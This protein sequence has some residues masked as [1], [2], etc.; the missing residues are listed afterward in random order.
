MHRAGKAATPESPALL[1]VMLVFQQ[2]PG[3]RGYVEFDAGPGASVRGRIWRSPRNPY[4]TV[5]ERMNPLTE[6]L[7]R[8]L[9]NAGILYIRI[10]LVKP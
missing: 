1:F 5:L 4:T 8:R 9:L 2:P 3:S 7:S 10:V 6:P